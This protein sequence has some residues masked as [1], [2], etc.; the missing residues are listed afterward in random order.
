MREI[1][2]LSTTI[3]MDIWAA[4]NLK[5][6]DFLAK[7]EARALEEFTEHFHYDFF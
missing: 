6:A 3:D 5:F 4:W 1:T 7:T 2:S